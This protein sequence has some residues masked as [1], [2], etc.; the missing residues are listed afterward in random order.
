MRTESVFSPTWA[1]PPGRTLSDLLASKNISRDQ[2]AR[3]IEVS[4]DHLDDLFDGTAQLTESVA[5]RLEGLFGT[6]ASFWMRREEQYRE[7]LTSLRTGVDVADT[8]Y[9]QW[10]KDLPLAD[11]VRFGWL[12]TTGNAADKLTKCLSFFDVPNLDVWNRNY[13]DVKEA[14]AFRMSTAHAASMPA[15]AAWLRQGERE[16]ERMECAPWDPSVFA[17]KLSAIRSLTRTKDPRIF[18]NELQSLCAAAGVAAVIVRAPS[19]CRASGATFFSSPDRAILLLSFRYLTDDQF[20][21]SF[22]HEAGHLLLHRDDDSL[23]LETSDDVTSR[24]E[25]E[26]NEFA[27]ATLLPSE[28]ERRLPDVARD[29]R[30]IMR[31]ARDAGI[32][33]GIVVGQL[34]HRGLV[35]PHH[36]NN[37][38]AR[39]SW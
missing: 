31:L 18:I 37:L 13:D 27:A 12:E 20:W 8:S 11:M 1:V 15:T 19:G 2:L 6:S 29:A 26:A 10:L 9:M 33:P 16:S 32:A 5:H 36:F 14:V 39:Y 23:I 22:F 17:A 30:A 34:Q 7:Q 24:Q 21:F 38:K 25:V 4:R 28:Y 35:K 3:S